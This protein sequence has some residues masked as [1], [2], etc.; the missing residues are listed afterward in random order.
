[1]PKFN[2]IMLDIESLGTGNDA[3]VVSMGA[4]CFDPFTGEVQ[5]REEAFY[6]RI[7]PLDPLIGEVTPS[8][9]QWWMR[10]NEAARAEIADLS[11]ERLSVVKACRAF[12]QWVGVNGF[13]EILWSNGPT[14]DET[15]TRSLFKR[16]KVKYPTHFR[17]SSCCR[18]RARLAKELG[19]D[20][21]A[22]S[23]VDDALVS[24]NA[25]DDAIGQCRW[26]SRATQYIMNR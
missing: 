5:P 15:I 11:L 25:L 12:R 16:A 10:Q 20:A 18:T 17:G 26:V 23:V 4:V 24:H 9:V 1:M 6:V 19:Y 14:F 22:I 13:P 21:H 3:A 2:N 7:D 8:T